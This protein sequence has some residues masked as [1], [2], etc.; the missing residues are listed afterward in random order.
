MNEG[1]PPNRVFVVGQR[2]HVIKNTLW[3]ARVR[4][5]RPLDDL[6]ANARVEARHLILPALEAGLDGRLRSATIHRR[7]GLK[8]PVG[9]LRD[10]DVRA[11][12]QRLRGK[13]AQE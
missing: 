11:A 7:E 12:S 1:S 4:D 5:L 13:V 3:K 6:A 10:R 9:R 8:P 2:V